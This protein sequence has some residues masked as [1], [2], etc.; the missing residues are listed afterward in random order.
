MFCESLVH[1]FQIGI[2]G[3]CVIA[4]CLWQ[5]LPGTVH[6]ERHALGAIGEISHKV[7]D[8]VIA[9]GRVSYD[10]DISQLTTIWI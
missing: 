6:L 3:I 2:L 4:G 9:L 10:S 1:A 7:I 8:E 5:V